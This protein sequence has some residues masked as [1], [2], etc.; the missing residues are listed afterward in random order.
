MYEEKGEFATVEKEL[1][2][3]VGEGMLQESMN[4]KHF[5]SQGKQP[6]LHATNSHYNHLDE[7]ADDKFGTQPHPK[8]RTHVSSHFKVP[9]FQL[10]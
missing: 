10:D 2:Y 5:R 9:K 3:Q 8:Q 6:R 1:L 7:A 4:E